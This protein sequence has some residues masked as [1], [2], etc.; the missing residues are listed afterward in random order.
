MNRQHYHDALE[1]TAAQAFQDNACDICPYIVLLAHK[2][3]A[4]HL[5]F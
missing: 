1:Q 4:C 2:F 3:Y 5:L